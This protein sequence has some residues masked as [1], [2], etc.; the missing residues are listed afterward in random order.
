MAI[1]TKSIYS[2]R[3]MWLENIINDVNTYYLSK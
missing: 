1:K 2:N 3:G